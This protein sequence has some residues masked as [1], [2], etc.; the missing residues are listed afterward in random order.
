MGLKIVECQQDEQFD[1]FAEFFMTYR[2]DIYS[3]Y[4]IHLIIQII[5]DAFVNSKIILV[6]NQ[7]QNTVIGCLVY[8]V[9]ESNEVLFIEHVLLHPTYR[10]TLTFMIGA[11]K[12]LDHIFAKYQSI[13]FVQF[14]AEASNAYINN[15]SSKLALKIT[16]IK[17]AADQRNLYVTEKERLNNLYNRV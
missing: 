11:R 12:T 15:M 9:D 14:L 16:S 10:Q 3:T 2:K 4:D 6:L 5:C 13:K 1:M 7:Q 17:I 8:H